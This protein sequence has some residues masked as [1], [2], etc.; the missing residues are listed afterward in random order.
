[1]KSFQRIGGSLSLSVAMLACGVYNHGDAVHAA[2]P[3]PPIS[4]AAVTVKAA[5]FTPGD[6]IEVLDNKAWVSGQVVSV[7]EG[8]YFIHHYGLSDTSK[9]SWTRY[10]VFAE[11]RAVTAAAAGPLLLELPKLEPKPGFICGRVVDETGKPLDAKRFTARIVFSGE[12]GAPTKVSVAVKP[13]GKGAFE[14]H[15]TDGYY[16]SSGSVET[17]I[18]GTGRMFE[19]CPVQDNLT[20]QDS[21]KGVVQDYIWKMSGRIPSGRGKP[22]VF[23]DW[24]GGSINMKA[25][26]RVKPPVGA[27]WVFT[28]KPTGPMVDGREGK[29]LT[30]EQPA[31]GENGVLNRFPF[32]HD[33]PACNYKI[34]GREELADGSSRPLLMFH[35]SSD[36][37][38]ESLDVVFKPGYHGHGVM[39][40]E[41]YIHRPGNP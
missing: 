6:Y 33:L 26:V 17:D 4:A 1:M 22:D 21:R 37:D 7:E 32:L 20:D 28:L 16:R 18:N 3:K 5:V 15:A 12:V 36:P 31:L 41:M 40:Y 24:Y 9:D 35:G 25:D 11:L 13:D 8:K 19:L 27:K 23:T 39:P 30:R 10:K 14:V 2:E 38:V 29:E 34:S